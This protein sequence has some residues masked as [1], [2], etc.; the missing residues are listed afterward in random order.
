M[1]GEEQLASPGVC[2][3]V[4]SGGW[5]GWPG[6]RRVP[7]SQDPAWGSDGPL[8]AAPGPLWELNG[9]GKCGSGGT[10]PE[11]LGGGLWSWGERWG[12][13]WRG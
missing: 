4:C 1:V 10:A 5:G 11:P 13:C 9:G 12:C 2:T 7:G 8:G 6:T 3:G